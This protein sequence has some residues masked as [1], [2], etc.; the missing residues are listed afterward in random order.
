MI[1]SYLSG[2][3]HRTKINNCFSEWADIILGIP[4]GSILGPLLFNIHINDIFYFVREDRITNYADDTTP[5]TINKK[6]DVELADA[7]Q[8]DAHIVKLVHPKLF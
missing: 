7:L 2:R 6:N 3:K 4:Q 5:Y 1:L 8:L